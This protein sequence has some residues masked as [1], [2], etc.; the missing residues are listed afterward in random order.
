MAKE[1]YKC[2]QT[3]VSVKLII[4]RLILER[5]NIVFSYKPNYHNVK[6]TKYNYKYIFC[7]VAIGKKTSS[8]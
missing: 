6:V 7:N 2:S 3:S 8:N 4:K 5:C 1:V